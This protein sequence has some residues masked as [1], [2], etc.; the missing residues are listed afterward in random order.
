MGSKRGTQGILSQRISQYFQSQPSWFSDINEWWRGDGTCAN[1]GWRPGT[2][3]VEEEEEEQEHH[4]PGDRG[5]GWSYHEPKS[6][7]DRAKI[8]MGGS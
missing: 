7:R 1:S 3:I 6:S 5:H 2:N 8:L 4:P